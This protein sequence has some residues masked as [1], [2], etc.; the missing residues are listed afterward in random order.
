M[1]NSS[2]P[3]PLKTSAN[4]PGY[5]LHR[6][7]RAKPDKKGARALFKA[8]LSARATRCFSIKWA[9]SGHL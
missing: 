2:S 3:H 7:K 8:L 4:W 1:T 5:F 9:E 6:S